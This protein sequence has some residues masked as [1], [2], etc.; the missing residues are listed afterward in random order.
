MKMKKILISVFGMFLV[1]GIIIPIA[2]AGNWST[3][4]YEQKQIFTSCW[5][6]DCHSSFLAKD[7]QDYRAC[8]IACNLEADN[9]Q[10]IEQWC[11]NVDGE[12]Y[13]T[14]GNT[15]DYLGNDQDDYCYTFPSNKKYLM[16]GICINNIYNYIQKDC[17]EFGENYSCQEGAC[18][19][20]EPAESTFVSHDMV[21]QG[22]NRLYFVYEPASCKSKECSML[23]MF[24]GLGG[25]A[26]DAANNYDIQELADQ[27]SFVAVFPESLPYLPGKDIA[28]GDWV[29][30][31]DYDKVGKKWD[32]AHIQL[33]LEER[34]YTQDVEFVEEMIDAV[35]AEYDIL[36]SQIFTTGHSYGAFFSYY[37]A[38]SLPEKIVAFGAHSGGLANFAGDWAF[39]IP[40]RSADEYKIPGIILYSPGD[41]TVDPQYSVDLVEEME[42][43]GQTAE[44]VTLPDGLKH[45]WDES[46]NQYQWDFFMDNL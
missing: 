22:K 42:L 28:F 29:V 40:V 13:M 2:N 39:P 45:K 16:E 6:S 24:H 5:R 44:L 41:T 38:M 34:Y 33:P 12:D 20:V 23:F 1:M 9:Y 8:S 21:V 10:E 18:V 36:K 26:N 14:L 19:Y 3:W 25:T 43:K 30:Y 46:K 15:S 32:I 4:G 11:E 37:V 17:K 31:D 27:N 7:W 35:D